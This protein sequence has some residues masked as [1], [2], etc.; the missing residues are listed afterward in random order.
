[1]VHCDSQRKGRPMV[2]SGFWKEG[3]AWT[4]VVQAGEEDI[5]CCHLFTMTLAAVPDPSS[6]SAS[7]G[8]KAEVWHVGWAL[9]RPLWSDLDLESFYTP[10]NPKCLD[11]I[12]FWKSSWFCITQ[13]EGVSEPGGA[14]R[15]DVEIGNWVKW[16][17]WV[18]SSASVSWLTLGKSLNLRASGNSSVKWHNGSLTGLLQGPSRTSSVKWMRKG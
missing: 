12:L 1:M 13:E 16:P 18:T 8:L 9:E 10:S 4:E 17:W 14:L 6:V 2:K 11:S 15:N 3:K 5:F 7:S